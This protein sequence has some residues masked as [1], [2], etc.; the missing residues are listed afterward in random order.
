VNLR[1]IPGTYLAICTKETPQYNPNNYKCINPTGEIVYLPTPEGP[2][3]YV[4]DGFSA[5]DRIRMMNPHGKNHVDLHIDDFWGVIW[6][7]EALPAP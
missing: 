5:P 1:N 2:H 4:F 6:Q 7:L 3:A